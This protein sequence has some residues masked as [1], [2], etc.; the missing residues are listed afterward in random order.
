MSDKVRSFAALALVSSA[1]LACSSGPATGEPT[2]SAASQALSG[3]PLTWIGATE[4]AYDTGRNGPAGTPDTQ[5]VIPSWFVVGA[6]ALSVLT[7]TYPSHAA[8]SVTVFW[9]NADYSS[10]GS[11]PMTLQSSTDGPYGDNDRFLGTIPG[12]ALPGG[13]TVHYWIR[14]VGA[15]G[16]TLY[17]SQNGANYALVPRAL[18]VG[19][20]GNLG[21][22]DGQGGL[23]YYQVAKLFNADLSTTVGCFEDGAD[24]YWIQAVQ[25]YVPGLTDQ[26][27][28]GDLATAASSLIAAQ[29]WTNMRP[30]GWGPI[31]TTCRAGVGNNYAC[32]VPF[33]VFP[34]GNGCLPG[35]NVPAGDYQYK[36]RFSVDGGNTWYWV[37][38]TDGSGGGSNLNVQYGPTCLYAGN[39]P[40]SCT[41]D[42]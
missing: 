29:L 31:P 2:G 6:N 39:D 41:N 36:L 40:A 8:T 26:G 12:S 3:P 17:D 20:A 33:T 28:T 37:G 38:S 15:N 30:Q 19:W 16:E 5:T 1:L 14:A 18:S 10:V 21:A 24:D 9:A 7:D 4:L 34:E 27:Y 11:A 23:G 13:E 35:G 42:P 25:V 22:Y 32:D